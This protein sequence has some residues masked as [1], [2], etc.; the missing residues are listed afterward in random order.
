MHEHTEHEHIDKVKKPPLPF[1]LWTVIVL[2][3]LQGVL[4]FIELIYSLASFNIFSLIFLLIYLWIIYSGVKLTLQRQ[5]SGLE[6]LFLLYTLNIIN[7]AFSFIGGFS[8]STQ[9]PSLYIILFNATILYHLNYLRVYFLDFNLNPEE[10]RRDII[11]SIVII[12]LALILPVILFAPVYSIFTES[13]KAATVANA[14]CANITTGDAYDYCTSIEAITEA[15]K[16][17]NLTLLNI[18]ACNTFPDKDVC[19]TTIA[20]ITKNVSTCAVVEK[21]KNLC[22]AL[23][24]GKKE[25]CA[26]VSEGL[27]KYCEMKTSN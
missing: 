9:W 7:I 2:A 19:I 24:T 12:I 14:V 20:K 1:G 10:K 5:K 8:F 23:A 15:N 17:L 13:V 25:F 18:D 4:L 16:K 6:R 11:S 26:D 27:K 22:I 21:E 3:I